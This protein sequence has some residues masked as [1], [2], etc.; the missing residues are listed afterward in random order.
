MSTPKVPEPEPMPAPPPAPPPQQEPQMPTPA[1]ELVGADDKAPTV[2][3]PASKRK[4]L[5]QASSG[6]SALKIPLNTGGGGGAAKKAS[7][8]L[9]IPT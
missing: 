7:S 8:G 6:T 9:N 5:Q 4:Q 1:P 3:Q 2:K